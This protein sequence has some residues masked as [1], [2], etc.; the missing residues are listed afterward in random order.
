MGRMKRLS[1]TFYNFFNGFVPSFLENNVPV[2]TSY[3]YL[4]YTLTDSGAFQD[5]L[6]QIKVYDKSTSALSIIN[7]ADQIGDII[8]EGI[9]LNVIDGGYVYMRKGEPFA[10]VIQGDGITIKTIYINIIVQVFI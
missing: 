1:Q 2:G 8:G 3:P 9:K 5:N 4:T 7:L 6:L 10:Q